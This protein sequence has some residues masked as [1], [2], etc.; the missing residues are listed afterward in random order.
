M[1]FSLINYALFFVPDYVRP[2]SL[3]FLSLVLFGLAI[4]FYARKKKV[5]SGAGVALGGLGV[6]L[7]VIGI[8]GSVMVH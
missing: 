8:L 2:M 1:V 3:I 5:G 4:I 6:I 7:V